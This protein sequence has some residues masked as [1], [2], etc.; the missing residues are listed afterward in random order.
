MEN[1]RLDGIELTHADRVLFPEQG[2][3]KLDLARYF[4]KMGASMLEHAANRLVS[5]VRCPQGRDGKCFFQRHAGSGLPEAFRR[6]SVRE[7]DGGTAEYLYFTGKKALIAAAQ[8]GVLELHI[9]GS[10]VDDIERPDRLVF[11]L[12]PG[13]GVD[14]AA[15]KR[16][17]IHVRSV[18][19][20][21]DIG[22]FP[23]LTGG[24][25]IHVVAPL[26]RRHEWPVVS[27]FAAAVA[28]R[29]AGEDPKRYVATVSKAE[30]KG[31]IF[32][33]YLR[34]DRSGTAIAP[35]S[36]RAR[37]GAPLAWPVGW[38]MLD[39]IE[40]ADRFRLTEA[41]PAAANGWAGYGGLRQSLKADA[42]EEVGVET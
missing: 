10:K 32:I 11:D 18:L 41:D 20:G 4:D 12:D 30:R 15:V 3:T 9:W 22:S 17:A 28:K 16:A 25:G 42:L 23:L 1:P 26:V 31:R 37:A 35:F 29:M 6:K 2:I 38:E 8:M 7:K 19:E 27:A 13:E 14:F 21:F 33:D 40:A 34:N 24:K 36:P 39:D 5:L